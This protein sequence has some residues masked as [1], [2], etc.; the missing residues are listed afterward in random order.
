MFSLNQFTL[1]VIVLTTAGAID[2]F[3]T[4]NP[5]SGVSHQITSGVTEATG[6]G[7]SLAN[8][9]TNITT[10]T[11]S[12]A[13]SVNKLFPNDPPLS[14][15]LTTELNIT[16]R[17][18]TKAECE[19][20]YPELKKNDGGSPKQ[21]RTAGILGGLSILTNLGNYGEKMKG[22]PIQFLC[23]L[24]APLN[25]IIGLIENLTKQMIAAN[26]VKKSRRAE[27][28]SKLKAT[29]EDNGC[30]CS[31]Y[32]DDPEL[33]DQILRVLEVVTVTLRQVVTL[34]NTILVLPFG[35]ACKGNYD[36]FGAK[37]LG[38]GLGSYL[39]LGQIVG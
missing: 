11:A 3:L 21:D 6:L 13:D 39:P 29:I 36:D 2:Q 15:N 30:D 28:S 20:I 18:P 27:K 17:N 32:L 4:S 10:N 19:L 26:G 34:V 38:K 37:E 12:I 23:Y 35:G 22:S 16:G 9:I 31:N 8:N 14:A 33:Q 24:R 1:L 7:L 5:V 25:I